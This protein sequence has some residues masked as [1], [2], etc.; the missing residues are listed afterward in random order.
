MKHLDAHPGQGHEQGVVEG[1]G[2]PRAHALASNVG[3]DAGEEEEQ[4]E[5]EERNHQTQVD[6][7][8]LVLG[9]PAT[10][11]GTGVRVSVASE[12]SRLFFPI[13]SKRSI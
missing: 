10:A 3:Q 4:I 1:G 6:G 5:T 8:G 12:S 2:H 13:L 7:G 11:R 9:M